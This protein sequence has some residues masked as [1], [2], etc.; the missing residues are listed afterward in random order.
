[1][2]VRHCPALLV[3][4]PASGQGK[5]TVTAAIARYH[6]NA[7]RRVRVFKS[8]PDFLDPMWLTRASGAP[9]GTL[10]LWLVGEDACRAQLY[11]AAA[12]ADLILVEG[13]MGL[14]DGKPSSADIAQR[15][16][17]PVLGVIN[18]AAM[19]QT[20]GAVAHGL[21]TLRS[22]LPFGGVFANQVGS[23]RHAGMLSE[24]L[25]ADVP[26]FGHLPR[27]P[28]AAM[29]SRHLGLVQAGE[30]DDAERRL[31]AAVEQLV[32]T[33][34]ELP[35]PVAFAPA[36]VPAPP[37]LLDGRRIA[38]ARDAVFAFL[39][40]ANLDLLAALGA[41]LVY[42][43][44]LAGEALPAA[45][46]VW[47]PGGYPELH[48]QALSSHHALRSDLQAHVAAG[49]PLL[50]E[51]GGMLALLDTLADAEG[52]TAPMWGLLP[53]SARLQKRFVGLGA[54]EVTLPEGTLRGHTYHHARMDSTAAP[55]AVARCP[56]GGPMA[57]SVYRHERLTASFVHF[58]FPSNPRAAA[59]LFLP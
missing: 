37:R 21:A 9:V 17:I 56:N 24:L 35:P 48:L 55:L 41:E 28:D 30:V 20:F 26:L 19:A 27:T 23:P 13:V 5:T 47:L 6:R 31:D 43:S 8:G 29:P 40:P 10:D 50:A 2:S 3:A 12:E 16:G 22:G 39:Y 33:G 44:P 15:L 59:Q 45:D 54:Q 51:C 57:E 58:W 7:G 11:E 32:W 36:D 4:A 52:G 38:V 49:K 18:A 14:F 34:P 46:A 53:G 25:P 42:F 1:M